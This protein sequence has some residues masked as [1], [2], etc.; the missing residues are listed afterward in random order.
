[1]TDKSNYSQNVDMWKSRYIK[2]K[3]TYANSIWEEIGKHPLDVLL[4]EL[5]TIHIVSTKEQRSE[6]KGIFQ[7]KPQSIWQSFLDRRPDQTWQLVLFIRR[8]VKML[9]SN[10]Q[11]ELVQIG[12]AIADITVGLDDF[13]DILISLAIL[14]FGAERVGIDTAILIDQAISNYSVELGKLLQN[15]KSWP[16]ETINSSIRDFGPKDWAQRL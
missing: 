11:T 2:N 15:L 9:T 4:Q 16:E 14:K 12:S 13:R 1:M 7:R 3:L 8:I 10:N 5:G 6:I